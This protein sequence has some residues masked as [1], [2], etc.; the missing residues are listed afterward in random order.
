MTLKFFTHN[1]KK[2]SCQ[3]NARQYEYEGNRVQVPLSRNGFYKIWLIDHKCRIQVNDEVHICDEPVVL[4]ANPLVSYAYDSL[5]ERRSGYW[6]IFTGEFLAENDPFAM[7]GNVPALDPAYAA[8]VFPG[9][10]QLAV[11]KWLFQQ[12]TKAVKS[13]FTFRNEMVSSYIRLLVFEGMKATCKTTPDRRSEAAGRITR[14]FLQLLE[15]QFPVRA[16]DRPMRLNTAGVFA[17][18]LAIHVNHLNAMVRKVT[19]QTTTQHIVARRIAEAKVLL[20]HTDWTIA[21][22]SAGLGFDY[23]NHFNE[24]FKRNTGTT[25]LGYRKNKIL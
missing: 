18:M 12:L 9:P 23:P 2:L 15:K 3:V 16:P 24:F 20:R 13:E 14:Q 22:I 4:F 17:N 6:C 1:V 5:Q 11:I 8:I 25:P 7:T 10:E 21:D 19:G